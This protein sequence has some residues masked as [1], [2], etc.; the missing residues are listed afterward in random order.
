MISQ[1]IRQI[2]RYTWFSLPEVGELT[3]KADTRFVVPEIICWERWGL[4][5][6][7]QPLSIWSLW[8]GVILI[9]VSWDTLHDTHNTH[10]A[11]I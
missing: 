5:H 10:G 3:G 9:P 2:G 1:L 11:T 8:Y 6:G 7:L 4:V